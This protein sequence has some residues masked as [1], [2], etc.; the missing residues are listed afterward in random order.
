MIDETQFQADCS[1]CFGL[2]CTALRL[3]RSDGFGHDKP[4]GIPCHFLE[5]SYTCKIHPRRE[6]LGYQ[7]CIDFT[8]LGA[9]QRASRAFAGQNWQRNPAVASQ[10]FARFAQLLALQEIRQALIDAEQM[11]LEDELE[12]KRISMLKAIEELADQVE[13]PPTQQVNDI[14]RTAKNLI[15]NLNR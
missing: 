13:R 12:Q 6:D 10:L 8:C 7:G 14:L 1:R 4:P 2:C 11:Q 5:A 3:E 15:K 9:G